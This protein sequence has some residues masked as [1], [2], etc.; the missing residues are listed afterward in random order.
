MISGGVRNWTG[1]P[2]KK[3]V[4]AGVDYSRTVMMMMIMMMMMMMKTVGVPISKALIFFFLTAQ[5]KNSN[6]RL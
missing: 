1:D 4:N 6:L 3:Q 5:V 2:N